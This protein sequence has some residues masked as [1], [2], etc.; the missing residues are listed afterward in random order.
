[1]PE[2]NRP[3]LFITCGGGFQGLTWIKHARVVKQIKIVVGDSFIEHPARYLADETV[4]LP[5]ISDKTQYSAALLDAVYRTKAAWIVPAT[6]LDLV[7]LDS[8]R[9]SLDK[10]KCTLLMAGGRLLDTLLSKKKT[11]AWLSMHSI[12]TPPWYDTLAGVQFPV[13]AKP[14]TGS[15]GKGAFLLKD[16]EDAAEKLDTRISYLFV[17]Y[18]DQ[19]EEY[20]IDFA[21]KACKKV[22]GLWYRKRVRTS[23][24]F[25]I[26]SETISPSVALS[27]LTHRLVEA[28]AAEGYDALYNVQVIEHSEGLFVSD[29]NPRLGTSAVMHPA[30]GSS[31]LEAF[32]SQP[33]NRKPTNIKVARKID[34]IVIGA[35]D[36]KGVRGFVFDLDDTLLL[37]RAFIRAR[38]K[39]LYDRCSHLFRVDAN[40]FAVSVEQI[41]CEQKVD[42]LIDFLA[43]KYDCVS[44]HTEL[45]TMYRTCWPESIEWYADAEPVLRLLK[46]KGYLLYI[47][48]DNPQQT[49]AFKLSKCPFAQ[50]FDGIVYTD[51]LGTEKPDT[52][53]FKAIVEQSGIDSEAW[54]MVGDHPIRDAWGAIRAGFRMAYCINRPDGMIQNRTSHIFDEQASPI[55]ID[56]L[57]HILHEIEY[58]HSL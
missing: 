34:E 45:L 11:Y 47:L 20:S 56:S 58:S 38:C 39:L 13:F 51:T 41:L 49:Q 54:V 14:D 46:E 7:I 2:Q 15:G 17:P 42:R 18:L 3:V 27:D 23:S 10:L 48:T 52:K 35:R 53:V 16:A 57:T 31:L 37:H 24:G 40:T 50:L 12:S 36:F 5:K 1:M 32:V 4:V 44:R 43:E 28:L 26:V 33:I 19:F 6:D 9:D 30:V 8:L 55:M 25:A 21:T 22:Y 29:I